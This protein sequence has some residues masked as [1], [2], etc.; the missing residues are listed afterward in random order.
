SVEETV[1]RLAWAARAQSSDR[2]GSG[3]AAD[4]ADRIDAYLDRHNYA[5]PRAQHEVY[6]SAPAPRVGTQHRILVTRG[7]GGIGDLLMMTPGIRAL[8]EMNPQSEIVFAVPGNLVALLNG[9]PHCKVVA[10]E[11]EGID[12]RD[13]E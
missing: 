8:R 6:F 9:N 13:F 2:A 4:L 10:I 3:I 5:G 12:V 1:L 11:A 7:V